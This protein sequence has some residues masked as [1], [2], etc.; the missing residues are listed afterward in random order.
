M[1][2]PSIRNRPAFTLIELL[3]VIAII[4]ILAAMLLPALAAAKRKAYQ[5]NCVSNLKQCSLGLQM[6]YNDSNDWL[7]PGSGS[8]NPP[9]PGVNYGLTQGQLP[10]YSANTLT[11]KWLP[12]YLANY[13]ALP[14]PST[15][16]TTTNYVV[17]LFCCAA[18]SSAV[19]NLSDGA[20]GT[21]GDN[22]TA[23]NYSVAF[24]KSTGV[25]SYTVTQPSSSTIYL[26]M[27]RAAY[28]NG[29]GAVAS[30]GTVGWLP[31]GKQDNYEP[32][33]L[34]RI[35]GAG[36]PL[37]EFWEIGDYDCL[38]V[39][40]TKFDL[41]LTPVHKN[42]RNFAYFDGHVGDRRVTTVPTGGVAAGEYDQ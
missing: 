8:R 9:G 19:G 36:V 22:P 25:G 2:R 4:A 29:A 14:D 16:A 34:S 28:P 30:G 3:V 23:N 26:G 39:N 15:I 37:S 10:L 11:R 1:P 17:K 27:L 31:F 18:Y 33:K 42:I 7:P 6:Y 20:G 21:S 24:T 32:T 40:S 41:A 12:F 13:L 35:T 38:A 5:V